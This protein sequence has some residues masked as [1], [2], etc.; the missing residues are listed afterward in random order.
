MGNLIKMKKTACFLFILWVAHIQVFSKAY[1]SKLEKPFRLVYSLST[2][3]TTDIS[4]ARALV[5]IL[6]QHIL[7]RFKID[8]TIETVICENRVQL[9]AELKNGYDG[10]ILP[11]DDFFR[12][13][14][15]FKLVPYHTNETAG[16]SGF[17]FLLAV[18][19]NDTTANI[20]SLKGSDIIIQN[21]SNNSIAFKL[22]EKILKD[23]NLPI[24]QKFFGKI[25]SK[26]T[27]QGAVLSLA[28]G[29]AKAALFTEQS[30]KVV[31]ELNPDMEKKLKI[32]YR[33]PRILIG[34]TCTNETRQYDKSTTH[35]IETFS[36]LHE[37]VYGKQLLNM[38]LCDKLVPVKEEDL[39]NTRNYFG[40]QL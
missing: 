14:K 16:E 13:K 11:I 9:E 12:Y 36:K 4:E 33:S 35:L 8:R 6:H 25:I 20:K 3:Q 18:N 26:P 2:L 30:F 10:A 7:N 5:K 23:K 34:I 1:N 27:T 32:I 24:S 39:Q 38:F 19:K 40:E 22:L 17:N 28:L 37:D 29:K 21:H 15:Q 31:K